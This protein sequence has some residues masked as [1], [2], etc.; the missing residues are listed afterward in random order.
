[1]SSGSQVSAAGHTLLEFDSVHATCRVEMMALS[2]LFVLMSMHH[3]CNKNQHHCDLVC[4]PGCKGEASVQGPTWEIK[5]L[6][7]VATS[8]S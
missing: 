5:K 4:S 7:D 2:N 3:L 1:M 8:V 6:E